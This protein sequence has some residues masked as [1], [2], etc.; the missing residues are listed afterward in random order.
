MPQ[1][2]VR[3][4]VR[5]H[6]QTLT[7]K[8]VVMDTTDPAAV[9]AVLRDLLRPYGVTEPGAEHALWMYDDKGRWIGE[10]TAA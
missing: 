8:T 5:Q 2:V 4:K 9:R 3:V 10:V 1:R 7:H 6:H